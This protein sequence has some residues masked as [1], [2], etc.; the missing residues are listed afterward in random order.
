MTVVNPLSAYQ[1]GATIWKLFTSRVMTDVDLTDQTSCQYDR[2]TAVASVV[3]K[4]QGYVSKGGGQVCPYLLPYY[5]SI[6]GIVALHAVAHSTYPNL[7]TTHPVIR[8]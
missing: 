5:S 8:S 3:F 7:L 6:P 1:R 4:T 2:L